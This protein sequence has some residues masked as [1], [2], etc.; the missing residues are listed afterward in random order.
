MHLKISR[1][2][3][4]VDCFQG[5]VRFVTST[6]ALHCGTNCLAFHN[7][8]RAINSARNNPGAVNFALIFNKLYL[9][10]TKLPSKHY[11]LKTTFS[12]LRVRRTKLFK[13]KLQLQTLTRFFQRL[14]LSN[15]YKKSHY[16]KVVFCLMWSDKRKV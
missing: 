5:C 6:S 13:V 14:F 2:I 4:N 3:A 9:L 8:L 11:F 16:L 1:R 10:N 12:C 15:H 7:A